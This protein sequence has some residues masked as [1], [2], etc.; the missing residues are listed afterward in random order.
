MSIKLA[1]KV[2]L[3]PLVNI[4]LLRRQ[5][6]GLELTICSRIKAILTET[7]LRSRLKNAWQVNSNYEAE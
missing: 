4:K 6:A 7:R 3:T 5:E 2:K 1:P